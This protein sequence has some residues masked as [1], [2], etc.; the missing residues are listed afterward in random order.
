MSDPQKI[1]AFNH[2]PEEDRMQ[3][4]GEILQTR[5]YSLESDV[6]GILKRA[7][8]QGTAQLTP[9]QTW[10]LILGAWCPNVTIECS[11]CGNS[12][13]PEEMVIATDQGGRCC[14]CQHAWERI[15]AE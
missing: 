5:G 15:L 13:L 3:V 9:K 7:L 1:D 2:L 8:D 14:Y 11:R 4:L 12:L 6:L 10:R